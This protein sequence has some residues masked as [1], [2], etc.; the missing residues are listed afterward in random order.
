MGGA[1]Y[2]RMWMGGLCETK[3]AEESAQSRRKPFS[4]MTLFLYTQTTG[5]GPHDVRVKCPSLEV[6]EYFRSN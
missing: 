6:F 1:G 2:M 5:T 3:A 4:S